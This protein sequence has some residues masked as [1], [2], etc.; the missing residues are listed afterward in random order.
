MFQIGHGDR[1]RL[2]A[3]A[4]QRPPQ[5]FGPRQAEA[6]CSPVHGGDDVVGN[7]TDQEIS[8]T[9]MIALDIIRG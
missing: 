9:L 2:D 7:V 8:H 6:L 5:I 3:F 4:S 1:G